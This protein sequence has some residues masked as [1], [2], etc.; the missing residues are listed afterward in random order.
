MQC[1]DFSGHISDWAN[2]KVKLYK[3]CT[4]DIFNMIKKNRIL[5]IICLITAL[6]NGA[7]EIQSMA[8][9]QTQSDT[10]PFCYKIDQ[11]ADTKI[12]R[13]QVPGFDDLSLRQKKLVYYL[14]E[15]ALS[16]RDIIWDQNYRH[17]LCIRQTLEAI[18][19]HYKGDRDT[20][21]FKNF[22]VYV[23]RIWFSNGIHHHYSTDKIAPEFSEE[24]FAEL[25][26]NSGGGLSDPDDLIKK[27][28]PI[29]FDPLVDAKRVNQDSDKDLVT[30]SANNFYEDVTQKEVEAY[31]NRLTDPEDRTP[32]SYGLNSKVTKENGN[33]VEKK[34]KLGGM[35]SQAIEK[36][37]YWLEKAVIVAETDIQKASLEKLIEY[38]ETGDLKTFD[39]Y[40]IL[41]TRDSESDVDVVNGFIEVYGDPLGMKATWESVVSFKD[42][43]ATKR[44]EI[45]SGNAQWFEDRSP[46][47]PKFRKKAVR[48][49][50]AT[51]IT[52][53]A[54][55]GDCYPSTPIGINLP[56]ADW[57]RKEHG[58][59][60]V[61][62]E[63][64]TYSYHQDALRN[65]FL[66]EFASS[67]EEKERSETYGFLAGNLHTDLH[68]CLGHGS[69]QMLPGVSPE[70][71]K[72]YHSPIEE[73]RADLF[74]L[75]YI[76][77]EKMLE[78][79]L[80]PHSDAAKAEYDS[81]IRGGLMTQLTRIEPDKTI[82]QAHMRNRQL[83]AKWVFE[84]GGPDHVVSKKKRGGKTYVIINDYEKLRALFGD[85]LKEI[86]RIKSEGDYEAA[87][88][89]VERYGVKVDS[90]LHREIRAR[91]EKLNL[92]PYSGF[93]NP[94]L[95]PVMEKGEIIDVIVEYPEDYVE[96][97]LDYSKN[98]SFLPAYN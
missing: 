60:S 84:K 30:H 6:F 37:V 61:T 83:I 21:D 19:D 7:E 17:N 39:E 70:A 52:V 64:I 43:E 75:Y 69:G 35:Y 79:G 8:E 87:K 1:F 95:K 2:T 62:L 27:L 88:S 92:A 24:Y 29:L 22:M 5:P 96:Q 57:I 38:Y 55:G 51:V 26:R 81:Y 32:V 85:L 10:D 15:A 74:A 89:L 40:S 46:V 90:E 82:E 41:W 66:D 20:E 58:S 65:G 78:L 44:T 18:L 47:D 12:L 11:F 31:Y 49:V 59:K 91:Y 48:G 63:N 94:V 80:I 28:T 86:Q 72:N 71:L 25:I 14:Y 13:Y 3:L 33:I 54:L 16:G 23:K 45:I 9:N 50:T 93:I 97:M 77:D 67:R 42:T 73:A 4:P 76:M 68:E 36:I 56:N 98:Y 53:A 34:W